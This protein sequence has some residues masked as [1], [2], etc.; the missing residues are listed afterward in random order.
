MKIASSPHCHTTFVDG[1]S[2]AEEMVLSAIEAGFVSIGFSD[3]GPQRIDPAYGLRDEDV[4]RYRQTVFSLR[5]KYK[6][7]LRVHLGVERDLYSHAERADFAYVIGA[8]HYF[9]YGENGEAFCAVDGRYED[10][11]AYRDNILGGDGARLAVRY[12]E[13][14]G[15][16]AL[17]YRPD[18]FA[19]FDLIKKQNKGGRL[20]DPDDPA[21]AKS[22]L[23]ALDLA[24]ESGAM[25]EVNTG[26]MARGYLDTPYPDMRYLKR[27]KELGGRAIVGSDCHFAPQI[28]YAFGM[29]PGYLAEAGFKTAWRLGA[30][31]E[32]QFVEYSIS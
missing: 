9:L 21:V 27:W 18:I 16:Y 25:L 20:Y 29:I 13:M 10:L 15:R 5:E 32:E 17:D 3:H 2:T 23:E 11:R 30:E 4:A 8:C 1:K 28:A 19:H 6:G 31:G 24:F 22:A 14:A 12:F 7:R 26:G